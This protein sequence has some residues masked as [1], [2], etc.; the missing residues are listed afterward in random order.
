[1][2]TASGPNPPGFEPVASLRDVKT[3]VPRVL[4]SI[5][6]AEPAPSGSTGTSRPCQGCS[7]PP[8]HHPDQAAL[9]STSLLRQ[10]SGEG[11]SPPHEPQRLTAQLEDDPGRAGR[12]GA[13]TRGHVSFF[14]SSSAASSRSI[15]RR[16]GCCQDQP[17]H[18]SS[19]HVPFAVY[20]TWNSRPINVLTRAR[21]VR[22][23]VQP[24]ASGPRSNSRSSRATHPT[25]SADR[26]TPWRRR[27]LHRLRARPA[28]TVPRTAPIPATRERCPDS[29]LRPRIGPRL[30]A[31]SSS[32][33]LSRRRSNRRPAHISQ[34]AAVSVGQLNPQVKATTS[35]T[36]VQ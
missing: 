36:G 25:A 11:L 26:A 27:P 1:M 15:A 31:G 10:V 18:R 3:P 19:A 32:E 29:S 14:H 5:P 2:R 34:T 9:S 12:R 24:W 22:W 21:V 20:M 17:W 8:R 4:L 6:L 13:L 7:R 30:P 23:S 16:A 35:P 33:P 28:A